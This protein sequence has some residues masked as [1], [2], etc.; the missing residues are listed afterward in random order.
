MSAAAQEQIVERVKFGLSREKW[1]AAILRRAGHSVQQMNYTSWFDLLVDGKLRVEVKASEFSAE[2]LNWQ[3]NLHRHGKMGRQPDF[4]IFRLERVPFSCA[5]VHMI[6]PGNESR[7]TISFS[8]RGLL[9]GKASGQIE[10]FKKFVCNGNGRLL[11]ATTV[12][13]KP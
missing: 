6:W 8:L 11:L 3:F 10:E 9:N 1:V 2:K 12:G 4:Y 5:A 13:L 7:A